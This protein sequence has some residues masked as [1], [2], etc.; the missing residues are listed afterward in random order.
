LPSFAPPPRQQPTHVAPDAPTLDAAPPRPARSKRGPL[1]VV[2]ALVAVVAVVVT[3]VLIVQGHDGEQEPQAGGSTTT[4]SAPNP[5]LKTYDE[6]LGFTIDVPVAWTRNSS[7]DAEISEVS[8]QGEQLDPT[9]GA[10]AV[11]VRRDTTRPGVGADTYLT[12]VANAQKTNQDTLDY[13][14]VREVSGDPSSADLEYTYRA[15]VGLQHYHVWMQ[16]IASGDV[17]YTLMFQLYAND[18]QTL[19][20]QWEAAQPLVAEIRTSFRVR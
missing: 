16:V 7:T 9:V 19:R 18:A 4:R 8:W 10:L 13:K 20:E 11:R 3:V 2:G 5:P 15:A 14:P 12:D 6:S 17:H 1:I